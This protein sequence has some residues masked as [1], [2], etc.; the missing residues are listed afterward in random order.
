MRDWLWGTHLGSPTIVN[1]SSIRER[2]R[3]DLEVH[4]L[5]QGAFAG[6][7]VEGRA[8]APGGP[9]ALAF[10]AGFGV[11][12]SAIHPFRKESQGIWHT[13]D[14]EFPVHQGKQGIG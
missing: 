12:N 14:D 3:A 11:V 8:R 4:H 1:Q 13:H 2:I 7:A 5:A 6:L 9:Y 10:P